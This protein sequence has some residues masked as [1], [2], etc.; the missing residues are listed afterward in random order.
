[1]E[2]R[3]VAV[4]TSC[5]ASFPM[6]QGDPSREMLHYSS[7]FARGFAVAKRLKLDVLSFRIGEILNC[8]TRCLYTVVIFS[9][10]TRAR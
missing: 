10:L 2:A 6:Q 1:M 5:V 9:L 3:N 8:V 4:P 7:R